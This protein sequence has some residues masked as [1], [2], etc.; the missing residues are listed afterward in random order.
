MAVNGF[1]TS[2]AQTANVLLGA[3]PQEQ[4]LAVA[5]GLTAR[6][7]AHFD[8]TAASV[9][10]Q[11]VEHQ[12]DQLL[13]QDVASVLIARIEEGQ[14]ESVA[15]LL[16]GSGDLSESLINTS[17]ARLRASAGQCLSDHGFLV[18]GFAGRLQATG[19]DNA[20]ESTNVAVVSSWLRYARLVVSPA[21]SKGHISSLLRSGLVLLG[22]N[23]DHVALAAK[24]LV[25]NLL[26]FGIVEHDG[27][28]PRAIDALISAQGFKL[29]QTLGYSLWN[30]CLSATNP[31]KA[32]LVR[33]DV[34][35]YWAPIQSGLRNGDSERR[36]LCLDILKRSVALAID[37]GR[38]E[39]VT[40]RADGESLPC[41]HG[42]EILG[43]YP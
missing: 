16:K 18:T 4:Q 8:E 1:S 2:G 20:S 5:K 14:P 10:L 31:D 33:V 17:K 43:S 15:R 3:I 11:L 9:V 40:R 24:D 39:L 7:Q 42:S 36:K 27:I 34:D 23:E 38:Q 26:K 21:S 28:L 12:T 19:F 41:H 32:P 30:R 25:F 37:I 6:L 13:R 29:H 35:E 22:S